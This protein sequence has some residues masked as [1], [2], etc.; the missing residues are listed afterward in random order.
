MPRRKQRSPWGT[1][2]SKGKDRHVI[3]WMENTPEG[4]KRKCRT[5][6]GT[7]RE[8]ALE[9]ARIRVEKADDR[10][11]P[12][13]GQAYEMWYRP[14]LERRFAEGRLK[15]NTKALYDNAWRNHAS[16][17]WSRVPLDSVRPLDVQAWLLTL[18]KGA[19]SSALVVLRKVG[20]F[21]VKYEACESNKFGIDY[22]LPQASRTRSTATYDLAHADEAFARL[23]GSDVEAPFILACFGSCRTGESLGVRCAEVELAESHGLSLAVVPITR[24]MADSGGA[25]LPDGDLKNP[26]SVRHVVIPEPYGT[27]L[28]EIARALAVD[29]R[30]WLADRGDGQ[31]MNKHRL[32]YRWN[33]AMGAERIPFANLRPSWRTIAQYEWG[34]DSDTLET[35]MGHSIPTVTGKHYLRPT[36]ENLTDSLARAVAESRSLGKVRQ[37]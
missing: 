17:R 12:T 14:W 9:L 5:F 18:A 3:R 35:L 8:A 32:K 27:R 20:E 29:G 31:P 23:R 13:V 28:A 19:A 16:P 7:Y 2:D 24:Q 10:P 33:A 11:V 4:R 30:E 22:E 25:P 34:V 21:A 15:E 36:V 26:Q 1:I 6:H 37:S